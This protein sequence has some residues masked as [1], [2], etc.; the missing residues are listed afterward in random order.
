MNYISLPSSGFFQIVPNEVKK[1]IGGHLPEDQIKACFVN[2]EARAQ[3]Y[4]NL[5][6]E[7]NQKIGLY[8]RNLILEGLPLVRKR[9]H[10]EKEI[11][12]NSSA[13]DQWNIAVKSLFYKALAN[14]K[15]KSLKALESMCRVCKSAEEAIGRL[16][17]LPQLIK[18]KDAVE[19]Q[20]EPLLQMRRSEKI[21]YA[22]CGGK[23]KFNDLK[24]LI[25]DEKN[26]VTSGYSSIDQINNLHSGCSVM[27]GVARPQSYP[28]NFPF[29][30]IKFKEK[31]GHQGIAIFEECFQ[32]EEWSGVN[33]PRSLNK[34]RVEFGFLLGRPSV[35]AQLK[36]LIEGGRTGRGGKIAELVK[37]S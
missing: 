7:T 32:G 5:Q 26:S 15:G 13:K 2:N 4:Q 20:L 28:N 1:I 11:N 34:D 33:L 23:K 17:R 36:E 6:E 9:S 30:A 3:F 29:I 24:I 22:L 27:R 25:L 37:E 10:L 21:L 19:K 12:E 31:S 16:E 18:E 14:N 8:Q 35:Y